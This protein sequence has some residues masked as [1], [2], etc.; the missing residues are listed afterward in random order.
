MLGKVG[1]GA[2]LTILSFQVS[3]QV[4]CSQL[5]GCDKKYCEIEKQLQIA[6]DKDNKKQ[7][8]GLT[9]S[10]D[11]AKKNCTNSAL[12]KELNGKIKDANADVVDYERDLKKAQNKGDAKKASKYQSKI[13]QKKIE[14]KSFEKDLSDLN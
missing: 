11:N 10:L 1:V 4:D 3:A 9:K 7:I 12:K 8:S 2:L 5:K 6:K 14:I 13:E